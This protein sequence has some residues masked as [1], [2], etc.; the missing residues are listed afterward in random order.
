[1]TM[2]SSDYL[3][4]FYLKADGITERPTVTQLA[5]TNGASA[6]EESWKNPG[7]GAEFDRITLPEAAMHKYFGALG[8]AINSINTTDQFLAFFSRHRRDIA[9]PEAVVKQE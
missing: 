3:R 8:S 1:M 2:K 9:A 7:T 6:F 5:T 4:N